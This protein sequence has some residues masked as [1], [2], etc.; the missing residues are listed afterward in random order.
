MTDTL[1]EEPYTAPTV[2]EIFNEVQ[3]PFVVQE[4]C[5]VPPAV[6]VEGFAEKLVTTQGVGAALPIV[7]VMDFELVA[8]PFTPVIV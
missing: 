2:G 8:D 4:S 5:A 1:P 3:L 6:I 7:T